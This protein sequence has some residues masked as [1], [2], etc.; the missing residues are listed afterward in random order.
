MGQFQE[1]PFV[2]GGVRHLH[3]G[4]P[5]G[6]LTEVLERM[7]LRTDCMATIEGFRG[8]ASSRLQMA[9]IDVVRCPSQWLF[10]GSNPTHRRLS[11]R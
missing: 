1:P 8:V 3:A 9:D 4:A 11:L 2:D 10:P 7:A 5:L 6:S